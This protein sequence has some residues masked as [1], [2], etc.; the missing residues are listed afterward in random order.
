MKHRTRTE[1]EH[2]KFLLALNSVLGEGYN[3][4]VCKVQQEQE[5]GTWALPRGDGKVHRERV[6]QRAY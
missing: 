2:N 3:Q 5:G 4:G 6:Q 1:K